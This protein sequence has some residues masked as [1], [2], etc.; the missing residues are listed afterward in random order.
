[1]EQV[2]SDGSIPMA[3]HLIDLRLQVVDDGIDLRAPGAE[4]GGGGLQRGH[5][6]VAL[7]V[8]VVEVEGP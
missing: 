4:I 7:G 3:A 1:M 5:S 8:D 6:L 2:V